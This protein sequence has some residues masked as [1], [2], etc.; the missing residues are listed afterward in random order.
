MYAQVTP[1]GLLPIQNLSVI[2]DGIKPLILHTVVTR[3]VMRI[4]RND[5]CIMFLS[6]L[7]LYIYTRVG[8]WMMNNFRDPMLCFHASSA[9]QQLVSGLAALRTVSASL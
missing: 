3:R 4:R 2:E 9:E 6:L 5:V 8:D 1:V 7:H